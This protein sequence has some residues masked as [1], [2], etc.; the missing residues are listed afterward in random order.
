MRGAERREEKCS[1]PDFIE[2]RAI[3]GF[4]VAVLFCFI[5]AS[6][7]SPV[8]ISF[9]TFLHRLNLPLQLKRVQWPQNGCLLDEAAPATPDVTN[10]S[11]LERFAALCA[12]S[13]CESPTSHP[14]TKPLAAAL[15]DEPP[16]QSI[17]PTVQS[18][19]SESHFDLLRMPSSWT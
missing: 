16:T 9:Q 11:I 5:F 17:R 2:E 12:G 13:C 15:A 10:S 18:G 8:S 14:A 7:G 1:V 6:R 3:A 19:V 4:G